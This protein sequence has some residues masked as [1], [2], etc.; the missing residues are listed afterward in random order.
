MPTKP[1]ADLSSLDL[2]AVSGEGSRITKAEDTTA[3]GLK[4]CRVTG[5]LAPSIGFEVRLPTETWTQRYLQVGCGGLCGN[6]RLTA[7]AADGCVPLQAGGFVVAGTDMGHQGRDAS[8]GDDPQKRADFAF[9]AQ[10]LTAVAAK[11]LILAYY[12]RPQAYA[13]FTGCSD[14]GREALVEAQRFP[15]DFNGIVAGAPAMNFQVQNAVFHAWQARA[16]TDPDGK[17]ILLAARLPVL[18]KAVLAACDR[19]DGLEDGLISDPLACRFDPGSIQCREGTQDPASCL[20]EAEVAVVRKLYDGP[21]DPRTNERLTV[22]G[23]LPGSELAWAGVYVPA[24]TNQPVF[25][26]F[27]ALDALRSVAFEKNPPAGFGLDDLAFDQATFDRLRPLHPLYDATNPDLSAF[28]A[29]GGKLI[30]WH[31]LADPHISPV[32][33]IAYHVALDGLM[34]RKRAEAFERLYLFPGM[35]HCAGGDGPSAFDLLTPM[36]AWVETGIAPKAVIARQLERSGVSDFGAPGMRGTGPGN[37]HGGLL[38]EGGPSAHLIQASP[39][40]GIVRSRPV[41]PYPGVA[42]YDGHGDPNNAESFHLSA[43]EMAFTMPAWMGADFYR[44]YV[45]L[46]R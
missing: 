44:P 7:G 5:L 32:N 1:C 13:Y 38:P 45:P 21:R 20:T 9:R 36:L 6:I 33:T 27:I 39:S 24:S 35:Y 31:G 19:L 3:N 11:K 22:A 42:A 16:N 14:G 37:P 34:G 26:R 17:A 23:P 28:E 30:L 12:G 2:R 10:H 46:Q 4:V 18:H 15:D 29:A 40:A 41:Y 25:S 43:S 8:F